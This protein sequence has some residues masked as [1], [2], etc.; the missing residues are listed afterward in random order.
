MKKC[1]FC[2]EEIKDEAKKCRHCGEWLE[3]TSDEPALMSQPVVTSE[4]P[5]SSTADSPVEYAGFWIRFVASWIDGII[6]AFLSI[7]PVVFVVALFGASETEGQSL[8]QL[9]GIAVSLVYYILLTYKKGAT[10]GKMAVGIKVVSEDGTDLSLGKVILRETVG[11]LLS[12]IT[13]YIGFIM[14][15]FT[16]K[17]QALHDKVASTCVVYSGSGRKGGMWVV[18]LV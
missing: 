4:A 10:W 3:K 18:I 12:T 8:G 1:P 5:A 11:K 2:S 17:K 6:L 7:I 14:A 13:L 15:A 9:V 16:K